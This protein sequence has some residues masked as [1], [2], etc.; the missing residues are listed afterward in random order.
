MNDTVFLEHFIWVRTQ[1]YYMCIV[2]EVCI[3]M[4]C[5]RQLGGEFCQTI[6]TSMF[7]RH[8]KNLVEF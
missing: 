8:K 2:N 4:S 7:V 3:P 5:I 1:A 6:L